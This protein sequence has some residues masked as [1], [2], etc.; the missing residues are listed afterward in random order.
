MANAHLHLSDYLVP[1]AGATLA[2]LPVRRIG[3]GDI[4][5]ALR[6][7]LADFLAQ[8]SHLLFLGFIYPLAGVFLGRLAIGYDVL[9]LLFPLIAGFALVG[10]FAAIGLYE[11][12][13]RRELGLDT[14]WS[15][16]LDVRNSPAIGSIAILGLVLT[17][18]FVAWLVA[19]MLIYQ[20]TMG[21][22][23]PAT[24]GGF[25]G[26]VLTTP[27]GWALI[28]FGNGVGFLFAV[29]ALLISVV[30]FP[31]LLDRHVN[32]IAA[33]R[34]SIRAVR[35]NPGMMILWGLIV[36]AGLVVGSLL[37]FAGLAIVMPVLGHATW[38]LYRKIVEA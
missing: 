29:A 27:A 30:S 6:Q 36:A 13:R 19:A 31:L 1:N 4:E 15:H 24:I 22:A 34:T 2:P 26:D 7:G 3:L 21:D 8:P 9:P 16:A 17:V 18:L 37:F 32:V 5:D 25:L 10:P 12:S 11:I 14:A 28:I 23:M 20:W 33:V 35:V 38:H